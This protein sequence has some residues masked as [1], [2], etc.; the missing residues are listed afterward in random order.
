MFP[1]YLNHHTFW[2]L[3][4]SPLEFFDSLLDTHTVKRL[5]STCEPVHFAR[6]AP[7]DGTN[8]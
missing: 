5:N 2:K 4:E 1:D 6:M 3:R 8:S 7:F